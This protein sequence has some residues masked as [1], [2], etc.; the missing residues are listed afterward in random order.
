MLPGYTLIRAYFYDQNRTIIN[1]EL[2]DLETDEI[3]QYSV[4]NDP[5]NLEYQKLLEDYSIDDIHEQTFKHI[6]RSQTELK[7]VAIEVAKRNGWLLSDVIVENDITEQDE[8]RNQLPS[9]EWVKQKER[10]FKDREK[11]LDVLQ[12]SVYSDR[13]DIKERRARLEEKQKQNQKEREELEA[14]KKELTSRNEK[15]NLAQE[16]LASKQERLA[17]KQEQLNFRNTKLTNMDQKLASKQEQL[18]NK[19]E[20]LTGKSKRLSEQEQKSREWHA[21]LKFKERELTSKEQDIS[22]QEFVAPSIEEVLLNYVFN[23]NVNPEF[24]F[25]LKLKM[26][27][28]EFVKECKDRS[29][30]K[31]LRVAKTVDEVVKAAINLFQYIE[32]SSENQIAC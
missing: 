23:T 14:K 24:I 18:A 7:R 30:K 26:F 31:E 21:N 11:Q 20:R 10:E 22:L 17:S 8:Y 4:P 1:C 27:E 9:D 32:Q 12:K 15:I 16:Q 13:K 29:L 5:E 28:M 25:N 19:Q 2:Q 6:R 3:T